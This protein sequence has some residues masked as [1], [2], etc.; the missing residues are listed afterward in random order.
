MLN[1]TELPGEAH[2]AELKR[3]QAIRRALDQASERPLS[4]SGVWAA[5]VTA[6]VVLAS[7]YVATKD[8]FVALASGVSIGA[9]NIAVTTYLAARKMQGALVALI[10]VVREKE[11]G[12]RV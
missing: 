8:P 7:V 12:G 4:R 9:M 3:D 2:I 1:A 10:G 11:K 5:Y 6:A